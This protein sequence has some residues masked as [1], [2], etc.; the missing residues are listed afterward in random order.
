[1]TEK[2]SKIPQDLMDDYVARRISSTQL[3]E[4]TG[5]H[6]VYLRRSIKRDPAPVSV[7]K[8]TAEEK[9]RLRDVRD[10]FRKSV[11]AQPIRRIMKLANVSHSTAVR[12]KRKYK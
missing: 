11:A 5:Y 3:A 7:T 8:Q 1:M 4:A 2:H 9:Q 12:I 6:A 10:A